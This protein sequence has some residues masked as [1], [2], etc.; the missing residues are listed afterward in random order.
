MSYSTNYH[1]AQQSFPY[2]TLQELQG[3]EGVDISLE[4]SLLEY[5]LTWKKEDEESFLFYYWTGNFHEGK[6]VFNWAALSPREEFDWVDWDSL[7][8][9]IGILLEEVNN[10]PFPQKVF[11][12]LQYYG[13]ENVFGSSYGG[14]L[15]KDLAEDSNY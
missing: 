8:S 5:G 12:L 1:Y 7:C 10:L 13:P 4:I 3:F 9:F 2:K 6:K 14:F 15:I 11:S